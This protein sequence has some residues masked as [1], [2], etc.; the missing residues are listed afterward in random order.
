M[1]Y[2]VLAFLLIVVLF[3]VRFFTSRRRA[4]TF[5]KNLVTLMKED[6]EMLNS[7]DINYCVDL[8]KKAFS[9]EE[10]ERI[11]SELEALPRSEKPP[12]LSF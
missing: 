8:Y 4:K 5:A 7:K 9:K 6:A 11:R 10:A 12:I 3:V 1:N 2:L